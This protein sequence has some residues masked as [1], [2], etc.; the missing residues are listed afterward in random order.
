MGAHNTATE[1]YARTR[2][3]HVIG[4]LR[5]TSGITA[6]HWADTLTE[7]LTYPT[8]GSIKSYLAEQHGREV[9]TFQA[10]LHLAGADIERVANI[11]APTSRIVDTKSR[12]TIAFFDG[13]ALEYRGVTTLIAHLG[14]Y[15]GFAKW[16]DDA[17]RL[18]AYRPALIRSGSH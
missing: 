8:G 3:E 12:A 7:A 13:S 6:E 17:V 14:L 9:D 1:H 10:S 11:W 4:L 16:G 18:I 5:E 2:V 15:V